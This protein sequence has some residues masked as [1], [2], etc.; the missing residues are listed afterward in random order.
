MDQEKRF[1]SRGGCGVGS[2]VVQSEGIICTWWMC[3]CVPEGVGVRGRLF[4]SVV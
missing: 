3:V 4:V 2:G 1:L